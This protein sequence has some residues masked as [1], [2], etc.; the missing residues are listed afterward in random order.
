MKDLR[1]LALL[2]LVGWLAWTARA[3][4]GA[5]A[6]L[7]DSPGTSVQAQA[8]GQGTGEVKGTAVDSAGNPILGAKVVLSARGLFDERTVTAGQDGSYSFAGL[9]PEQYRVTISAPGFETL[10]SPELNLHSGEVGTMPRTE[11]KISSTSASVNVT[12]SPDQ[13][14][15]AQVQ[16]Q[17]KQRVF[18]VFQNFYTSYIW[19][20][21]P[22]PQKLKYKLAARTIFDPTSFI[23]VAGIAGA[24]DIGGSAGY[25][26]GAIGYGERYGVA[27]ADS[28]TTRIIGSA[29]LPSVFHQD[30]RYYY[31]GSGSIASRSE[32]AIGSAFLTRGDNG[33]REINYSHLLGA[34]AAAGIGN[35]YRPDAGRGAGK[36]FDTWGVNIGASAIGNLFREFLLRKLEPSVPLFAN[37]K[38]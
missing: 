5:E 25:D 7:P 19:K 16:E 9:P 20:A 17:E 26:S 4:S 14:A 2:L 18:G 32:H 1:G 33:K 31:Q 8:P 22:M 28:V 36:V 24:Q 13:I 3:Q 10:M 27:F 29:I 11:L 38:H 37:G 15:M 6:S 23:I 34:L 21:E 12:A 30:P 35:Y